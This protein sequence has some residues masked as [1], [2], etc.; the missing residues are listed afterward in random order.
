MKKMQLVTVCVLVMIKEGNKYII[1]MHTSEICVID[2]KR[3]CKNFEY[4]GRNLNVVYP[5]I[6]FFFKLFG[7]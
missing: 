5:F 3:I 1:D 4:L 2:G 6:Q 7:C